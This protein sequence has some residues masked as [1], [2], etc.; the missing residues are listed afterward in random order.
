MTV[1]GAE[2]CAVTVW[3]FEPVP[4]AVATFVKLAVTLPSEQLYV[5]LAPGAIEARAGMLA[6]VWLQFGD[7]GSETLTLLSV[8]VPV[9][10][11]TIVKVAVAPELICC[12]FGFFVIEIAGVP[13]PLDGGGA[14]QFLIALPLFA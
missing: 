10:V 5:T 12:D 7:S 6:L 1:T 4:V 3:P 2:S 14:T 8:R 9:F 11:T 13:P